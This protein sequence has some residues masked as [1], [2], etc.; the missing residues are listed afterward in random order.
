MKYQTPLLWCLKNVECFNIWSKTSWSKNMKKHQAVGESGFDLMRF[1]LGLFKCDWLTDWTSIC[2][3]SLCL[4]K[5]ERLLLQLL[6]QLQGEGLCSIQHGD[7][8][9][10]EPTGN[11]QPTNQTVWE[12]ISQLKVLKPET[13][14]GTPQHF[15]V[16]MVH[17]LLRCCCSIIGQPCGSFTVYC[18]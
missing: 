3:F 14:G 10:A 5:E 12:T 2:R 16:P 8:R 15:D 1:L 13:V 18:L 7:R 17:L 4:Y 11:N 6:L 9:H